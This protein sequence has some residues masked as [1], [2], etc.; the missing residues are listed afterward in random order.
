MLEA[1]G[2]AHEIIPR[3]KGVDADCGVAVAVAPALR[4]QA[5]GIL[6]GSGSEPSRV[7]EWER[8]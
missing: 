6:R 8:P 2:V 7:L 1:A 3:P 4:E 5:L